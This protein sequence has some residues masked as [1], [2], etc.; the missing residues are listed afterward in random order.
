MGLD[1]PYEYG[2]TPIDDEEKEGLKILSISTKEE[3]N[4]LEQN[5]I[6]DVIEWVIGK[7]FLINEVLNDRFLCQL[8]KRMFGKVWH[9][10]GR[11][12]TSQKNLGVNHWEI[13]LKLRQLC[14]DA[15]FWSENEVYEPDEL[16][17]RCK[18]AI[19][20]IHCFP[21]GNGRHGRLLADILV[22]NVYKK[23][24]FSWGAQAFTETDDL[25]QAYIGALKQAD[26]GNF[27]PLVQFA[28]M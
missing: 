26:K 9:W 24:V 16:A 5:N 18:H 7:K 27:R 23:N 1:L 12:K 17:I 8:H 28:R 10:A 4:A 20:S 22:S 21:N 2:Q 13:A 6:E 25:R 3:L 14:D 19:V 11:Y 15:L